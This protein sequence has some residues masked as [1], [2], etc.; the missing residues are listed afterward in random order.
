MIQ[1]NSNSIDIPSN[2]GAFINDA[3]TSLLFRNNSK[4]RIA[5]LASRCD[6][7]AIAWKSCH[8]ETRSQLAKESANLYRLHLD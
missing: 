5:D 7:L 4:K 1:Y 2:V 8:D 6:G 3:K